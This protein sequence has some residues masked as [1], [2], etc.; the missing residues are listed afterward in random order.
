MRVLT[1]RMLYF[2]SYADRYGHWKPGEL[3]TAMQEMAGRHSLMLGCGRED[4][5]KQDV[6][7]VLARN[8]VDIYRMPQV[9]D[10]IVCTTY[11]GPARRTLYPRY[12]QFSLEDGTLLA[13]GVGG[14]TLANIHTQRMADVPD[15]ARNM[16][17]T[18]DLPRPVP[19]PRAVEHVEGEAI[20]RVIDLRYTDID[21]NQHVNNTRCADWACDLLGADVLREQ[22]ITRFVANYKQQI[23]P[24]GPVTLTL[25]RAGSRFSMTCERDGELLLDCGGTLGPADRA[26]A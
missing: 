25:R 20:T 16:P 12:H 4:L 26:E 23:L 18:S 14:W 19:F 11:P 13:S 17:D 9:N 7:W 15:I 5:L 8:E 10:V 1:E 24:T 21:V 6:I 22:P 2:S 3:M